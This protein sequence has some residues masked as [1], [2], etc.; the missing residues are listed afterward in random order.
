[1]KHPALTHNIRQKV[2]R[3]NFIA[4]LDIAKQE[5]QTETVEIAPKT[6]DNLWN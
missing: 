3:N 1:M 2:R 6:S 4:E 5:D